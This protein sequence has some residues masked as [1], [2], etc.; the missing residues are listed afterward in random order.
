MVW[1]LV[2]LDTAPHWPSEE[3]SLEFGGR[4]LYLRPRQGESLPDLR[5]EYGGASELDSVR[6]IANQFLSAWCW[7][8]HEDLEVRYAWQSAYGDRFP[9]WKEKGTG[10]KSGL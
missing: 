6:E 9:S 3:V 2:E 8:F 5:L 7:W 1:L 10:V 4:T